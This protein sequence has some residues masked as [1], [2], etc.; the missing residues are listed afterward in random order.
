MAK[1][2]DA[3]SVCKQSLRLG[4]TADAFNTLGTIRLAERQADAARD[5]FA[6]ALRLNPELLEARVNLGNVLALQGRDEEARE[7]LPGDRS[8]RSETDAALEDRLG[9]AG[10]RQHGRRKGIGRLRVKQALSELAETSLQVEDP[11]QEIGLTPFHLVYDDVNERPL[12]E[13]LARFYR[14][15]SRRSITSLRIAGRI[16]D[17]RCTARFGSRLSR[18][19]S[20][21]TPSGV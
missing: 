15:G 5:C 16:A 8:S 13:R 2:Q 11:V 18:S 21:I 7:M 9:T 6:A 14:R 10:D 4:P 19:I 17:G 3:I 12:Q 1:L 20:T